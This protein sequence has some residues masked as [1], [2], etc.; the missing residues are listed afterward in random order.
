MCDGLPC[1]SIPV[2]GPLSRV[3]ESE[4]FASPD[5]LYRYR[6]HRIQT[7]ALRT[8]L[9]ECDVESG[10]TDGSLASLIDVFDSQLIEVRPDCPSDMSKSLRCCLLLVC[11]PVAIQR[12]RPY[13]PQLW[14]CLLTAVCRSPNSVLCP[15]FPP[16]VPLLPVLAKL[17]RRD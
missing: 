5:L 10:S 9:Q 17:D 12:C 13:E 6:L 11:S 14:R 4:I 7:T 15:A 3:D 8:M 1:W 2:R 16:S